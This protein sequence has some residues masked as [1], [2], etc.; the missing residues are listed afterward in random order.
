MVLIV[1]GCTSDPRAS[2]SSTVPSQA[3]ATT[4]NPS[5]QALALWRGRVGA[6][7]VTY[8]ATIECARCE[9]KG[10]FRVT[11]QRGTV[12]EAV[13]VGDS[14]P[15]LDPDQWS[16]TTVLTIAANAK[17]PVAVFAGSTQGRVSVRVDVDPKRSGDEFTYTVS[18]IVV[19]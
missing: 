12:T 16:F 11:E 18:D 8:L 4:T 3:G 9:A 10:T 14:L 19:T 2:L 7:V 15:L 5:D 1:A 13:P 6:H 17:G